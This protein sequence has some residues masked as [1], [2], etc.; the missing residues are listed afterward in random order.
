M[1]KY[2]RVLGLDSAATL[3][4]VKKAYRKLALQFHPDLHS[5]TE[6]RFKEIVEAYEMI[7]SYKASKQKRR[8]MSA[9][10]L[11]RFYDLLK[12]AAEEKAREKAFAHAAKVRAE[13][14]KE[15]E[16]SYRTAVYSFIG[17]VVFIMLAYNSY[18]WHL[19]WQISRSPV[20]V[21][22]QV[23]GIEANRVVYTFPS[24]DSLIEDRRYVRGSGLR[25]YSDAGMPLRIGDQ[26]RIVYR[27]DDPD[28]NKLDTY[29]VSS[30]TFNRYVDIAA[31]AIIRYHLD[32][33]DPSSTTISRAKA[34]CLA[35]LIY[36]KYGIE[37]LVRCYH[38]DSHP[39]ERF[40]TNSWTWYFFWKGDEMQEIRTACALD[41]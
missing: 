25:M 5:G 37:G 14:Q 9:E 7:T 13:K 32:P 21:M 10:E 20:E 2:Y 1:D 19:D 12:K 8:S 31:Q 36:E 16:K 6:E 15:Q 34:K 29:T 33:L 28:Y 24:G 40:T 17:L 3:E 26:F 39:L 38:F 18:F 41:N 23:T 27:K 35:L 11:E 4:E 30:K 22:A